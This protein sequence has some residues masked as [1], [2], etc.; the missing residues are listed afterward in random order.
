MEYYIF[1]FVDVKGH[2]VTL[3]PDCHFSQFHANPSLEILIVHLGKQCQIGG[4]LCLLFV[5]GLRG[6]F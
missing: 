5:C 6:S 1:G 2:S 4:H 3:K